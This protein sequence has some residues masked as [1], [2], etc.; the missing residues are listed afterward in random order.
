MTIH[1]FTIRGLAGS[2]FSRGMD[3]LAAKL[4]A[5]ASV[6]ASVHAHG[7]FR[8]ENVP[9]IA[10]RA[11][12]AARLGAR[13]V[14]VG[15]SYGGDAALMVAARLGAEKVS[16][17]LLAAFDPTWFGAPPVPANV[18]RAIGFHQKVDPVGRGVLR[19]GNGFS[20]ELVNIRHDAPHVRM[21]ND[22]V[23]HAR[24]MTEVRRLVAPTAVAAE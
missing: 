12:Q 5:L 16:V 13:I 20:G 4:A 9:N 14:L 22:P 10:R 24:V 2:I 6:T 23:L 15:H 19:P 8:C 3:E 21:D 17:P 7:V 1:I 18:T 11:L